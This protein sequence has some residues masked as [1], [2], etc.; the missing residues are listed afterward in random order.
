MIQHRPFE[1]LGR[2]ERDWLD[3]RLHFR[4]GE[5]GRPE[6]S[7]LGP[8]HI[9]NDDTFA[10]RSG[11]GMHAHA[12]VEIVSL[13]RSGAITHED[14]FGNTGRIEAGNVQVMSAG[15]GIRHAERNEENEPAQLFQIWL[16]PRTCDAQPRWARRSFG[17]GQP[18]AGFV[19]VASGASA[20]IDAGALPI[21][22][23]ARLLVAD[24]RNGQCLARAL[25]K[26][27]Q[28]YL[29]PMTGHIRVNDVCLAPRDG[30]AV[31][32]EAALSI[33]AC[34]HTSIVLLETLN[35]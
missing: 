25:A 35:C 34:D 16:T 24:M 18:E 32:N 2:I 3:A 30:A 6:H 12:N 33:T 23:D 17:L 14:S 5:I 15:R 1:T 26:D 4:F 19:I 22:A 31:R 13:V 11:F 10:P 20:D 7:A 21:D 29:V 28:A 27:A 8:L 9:W